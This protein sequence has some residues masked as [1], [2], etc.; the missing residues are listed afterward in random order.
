MKRSVKPNRGAMTQAV[1][2]FLQAS[3]L[4][5]K[6]PNL[7]KTPQRVAEAWEKEFL[8]GYGKN[9]A[10]LL[11]SRF[12][13]PRD[14]RG[15]LVVVT[16][17]R[18]HSMCPHHLLPYQ[19]VAHL[20]YVPEKFVVGFGRLAALLDC[21]AHRLMLQ[22]DLCREVA[23]SLATV[24]E[25]PATACIVQAKQA[26]LRVRGAKQQDAETHAEAYEGRLRRDRPLRAELWARIGE[27]K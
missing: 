27:T 26:C 22:E 4:D 12:P 15:E 10:E 1:R 7:Q 16:G 2:S 5:L 9:P 25:S 17:L 3:G 18:F 20:A 23:S 8:D 13:A 11:E 24:L 14:S 21:F 19:G 6:D